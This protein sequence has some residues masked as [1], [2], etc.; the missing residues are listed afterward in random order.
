MV[1][2]KALGIGAEKSVVVLESDPESI[3]IPIFK[4]YTDV[5]ISKKEFDPYVEEFKKSKGVRFTLSGF[6]LDKI[7]GV[8][9][10]V[11]P[12]S[13]YKQISVLLQLPAWLNLE[14]KK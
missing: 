12:R 9:Y 3:K 1:R 10:Y 11:F 6:S 5:Y 13:M 7:K 8:T 2:T 14:E 4:K